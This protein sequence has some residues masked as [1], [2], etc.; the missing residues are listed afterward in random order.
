MAY[1]DW[2][3]NHIVTR[4]AENYALSMSEIYEETKRNAPNQPIIVLSRAKIKYYR[5]EFILDDATTVERS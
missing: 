2:R 5:T 3:R 4:G 1:S